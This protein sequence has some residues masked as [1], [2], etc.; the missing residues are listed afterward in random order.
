M[1]FQ[2]TKTLIL[3]LAS[4]IIAACTPPQNNEKGNTLAGNIIGG[5]EAGVEFQK[6]NGVVLLVVIME[7]PSPTGTVLTSQSICTGTLIAPTVVLSAAHCFINPFVTA[8]AVA[9]NNDISAT[10]PENVIF[11]DEV[12]INDTY[13]PQRIDDSSFVE[14]H[15]YGDIA[16]LKLKKAV[17]AEFK[18]A[19]MPTA[20][21]AALKKGDKLT[22]AGFGV[23]IAIQNKVEKDPQTGAERVVPLTT[24]NAGSGVLR[25]VED[26][27]ISKVTSDGKELA[28]D[29]SLQRNAC[30]GDSGGPA[31]KK[32]AEGKLVL[33]GVVSRGTNKIGNCDQ[34][35]VFTD[36]SG[37]LNWIN[38][39]TQALQATGT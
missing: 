34:T 35:G 3:V 6:E 20:D 18:P 36:V 37:Y 19:P 14:G 24:G 29:E 32:N 9:L 2:K 12:K 39:T 7:R 25:V 4:T 15:P 33:V 22:L 31:Y 27:A 13:N 8:V 38:S 26:V 1:D 28:V 17:P 5:K 16:L 23:N 21:S 30:H 11:V 10:K